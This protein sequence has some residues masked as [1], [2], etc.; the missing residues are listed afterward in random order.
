MKSNPKEQLR[1]ILEIINYTEDREAFIREYELISQIE[2]VGTIV[3][4][5]PNQVQEIIQKRNP[6][7][8]KDYVSLDTYITEITNAWHRKISNLITAVSPV[9]T[10]SQ[11][12]KIKQLMHNV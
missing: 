8:I 2:A 4:Q 11:K 10:F 1:E 7:L 9:L 12:E 3:E 6:A 5:L